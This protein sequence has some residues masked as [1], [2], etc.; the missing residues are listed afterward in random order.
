MKKI[1]F[2]ILIILFV[3][4]QGNAQT[5]MPKNINDDFAYAIIDNYNGYGNLRVF[6]NE[7]LR[8]KGYKPMD[9]DVLVESITNNTKNRN[10]ILQIF[11]DICNKDE[12]YLY[13][14]LYSL[15]IPA[16]SS[17][18][19]AEYIAKEK[20]KP[21]NGVN[22]D[23]KKTIKQT[24]K[25]A[26][27]DSQVNLKEYSP[28]N[29]TDFSRMNDRQM[30]EYATRINIEKFFK[31]VNNVELIKY[32]EE[33]YNDQQMNHDFIMQQNMKKSLETLTKTLKTP[34]VGKMKGLDMKEINKLYDLRERGISLYK[35]LIKLMIYNYDMSELRYE[36]TEFSLK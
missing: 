1:L 17:K 2:T 10:I 31:D 6:I 20:Y 35:K 26:N 15:G 13:A 21:T 16:S 19:L 12:Y 14:N 33:Y 18:Y 24:T 5:K 8:S 28:K 34:G 29:S 4:T 23:P 25:Y 9:I 11:S 30:D 7:S 3:F 27:P 36:D 32:D 22:S